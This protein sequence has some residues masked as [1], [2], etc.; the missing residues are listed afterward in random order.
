MMFTGNPVRSE[1]SQLPPPRERY[2]SRSG[3]LKL[4]VI[5]AASAP[6]R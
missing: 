5:G 3:R 4:L 6:K 1:I 2:A